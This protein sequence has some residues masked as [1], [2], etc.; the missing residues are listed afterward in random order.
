MGKFSVI[1]PILLYSEDDIF[2]QLEL[3]AVTNV[4]GLFFEQKR[5]P[6]KSPFLN[7]I[8]TFDFISWSCIFFALFVVSFC[9]LFVA[10]RENDFKG[11]EVNNGLL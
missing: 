3:T 11:L 8:Y 6:P 9:F 2:K 1:R 7:I 5:P 4:V 10:F